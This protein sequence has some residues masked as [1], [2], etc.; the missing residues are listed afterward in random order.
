MK[1]YCVLL[2]LSALVSSATMAMETNNCALLAQAAE[3]A[4]KRSD[5]KQAEVLYKKYFASP[6]C[7]KDEITQQLRMRINYAETLLARGKFEKGFKAFDVRLANKAINRKALQNPWDGNPDVHGK[8]IL[9][10]G[11]HGIGDTF[12]FMRYLQAL[13]NAGAYVVV[14][15]R[16][17]LKPI[18]LRQE[19]IHK[20]VTSDEEEQE[21]RYDH[22][23]YMMS[24]PQYVSNA[25]IV[26]TKT[27]GDIILSAAYIQPRSEL[28]AQ[29]KEKM[30]DDTQF[31]ILIAAYRAS[32][33]VAGECRQL[34]RDCP[35]KD[36]MQALNIP[37]V[38]LY[39]VP[40]DHTPIT[41][42]EYKKRKTDGALEKLD[43]LDVISDAQR[44][45]LK[46]FDGQFDKKNGAFEDTAAVMKVVD[47]VV[48]VD[49][50]AGQLA[51]AVLAGQ[52]T[53][54]NEVTSFGL[55]LP[56]ESDWRWGEG[57]PRKSP[58]LINAELFWQKRQGDWSVPFAQLRKAIEVAM[59]K[60][61]TRN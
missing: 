53:D 5:Y 45:R 32:T 51:G 20:V 11:E 44:D 35:I 21:L 33:N 30:R 34:E 13:Q 24:L 37:G 54:A 49:T 42:S 36:L 31:K 48:S 18:L 55:L 61:Q 4:F 58:F 17:F 14:R 27:A 47:Y 23:V 8:T 26:P 52:R 38:S 29:W 56:E 3:W 39:C 46:T 50:S 22:D 16:G 9:A 1:S 15:E 7:T 12:L 19:Y 59:Q 41:E 28:I 10:R 60:Q 2:L 40:G 43:E 6:E 25:G 57:Q